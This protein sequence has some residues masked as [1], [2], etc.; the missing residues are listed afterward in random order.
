MRVFSIHKEIIN[1]SLERIENGMVIYFYQFCRG[2][3]RYLEDEF[4]R[5]QILS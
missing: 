5:K 2:T 4:L 3:K 1:L